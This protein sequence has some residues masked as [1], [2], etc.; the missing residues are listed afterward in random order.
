MEQSM[1]IE[2]TETLE[3]FWLLWRASMY[4]HKLVSLPLSGDLKKTVHI[5][6]LSLARFYSYILHWG[7]CW[8]PGLSASDT[9]RQEIKTT[10]QTV[11]YILQSVHG[12]LQYD[13]TWCYFHTLGD[14]EIYVQ[15]ASKRSVFRTR[16]TMGKNTN[17]PGK[18]RCNIYIYTDQNMR[19]LLRTHSKPLEAQCNPSRAGKNM[20]QSLTRDRVCEG[21]FLSKGAIFHERSFNPQ[22]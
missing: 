15:T 9:K 5:L 19:L 20:A 21:T 13:Q 6:S 1:W 8:V 16:I 18:T 17:S 22:W 7:H 14:G 12:Y 4:V 3:R 11:I 2:S 10:T